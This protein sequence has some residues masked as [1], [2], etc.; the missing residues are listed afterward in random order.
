MKVSAT[1]LSMECAPLLALA[2]QGLRKVKGILFTDREAKVTEYV[3][4]GDLATVDIA[5]AFTSVMFAVQ[6]CGMRPLIVATLPTTAKRALNMSDTLSIPRLQAVL[7]QVKEFYIEMSLG[8]EDEP[9][10]PEIGHVMGA[11]LA[12]GINNMQR[13]TTL[14]LALES[15][16]ECADLMRH[17]SRLCFLP[18]LEELHLIYV[19]CEMDD[20]IALLRKHAGTLEGCILKSIYWQGSCFSS[21][22]TELA[23]LKLEMLMLEDLSPFGAPEMQHPGLVKFTDEPNEDGYIEVDHG[24]LMW[25]SKAEVQAGIAELLRESS[26]EPS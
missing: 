8:S 15:I 14:S 10:D 13:L 2:F 25:K 12:S 17:L 22:L 7:S 21:L 4:E 5:S 6:A 19:V 20:L 16:D 23:N 26:N 3:G 18:N 9:V 11:H 1:R 24:A